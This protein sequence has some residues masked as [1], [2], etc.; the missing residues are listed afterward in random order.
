MGAGPAPAPTS[1]SPT[2]R[3]S[4]RGRSS[5]SA[6]P[7]R[8]GASPCAN[9]WTS[10]S[11]RSAVGAVSPW[12]TCPG[13]CR[14]GCPRASRWSAPSRSSRARA[15]S[16]SWSPLANGRSGCPG[17]TALVST[18]WSPHS[19][20]AAE[21]PIARVRKGREVVDDIRPAIRR[22]GVPDGAGPDGQLAL[23]AEVATQPRGLRPT[24][25]VAGLASVTAETGGTPVLDRACR[26]K[27]WIE[28][29]GRRREPLPGRDGPDPA[30]R[31]AHSLVGA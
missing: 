3:G 21:V 6:W 10:R 13:R 4:L 11:T 20:G 23:V 27:Q 16:R 18:G 26:T 14:R 24:E 17:W 25:L 5:A 2:R 12:P 31:A 19:T 28:R 15:R 8:P 30:R 22:L 1:R 29:D 7:S 9:T